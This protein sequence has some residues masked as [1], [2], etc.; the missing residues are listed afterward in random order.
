MGA[1][2]EEARAAERQ[3]REVWSE[4]LSGQGKVGVGFGRK[5]LTAS[6]GQCP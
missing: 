5:A 6:P 4:V 1:R 3:I 2:L